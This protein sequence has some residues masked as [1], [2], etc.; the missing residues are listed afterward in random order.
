MSA[1][2]SAGALDHVSRVQRL[3]H[4]ESAPLAGGGQHLCL[5]ARLFLCF[6]SLLCFD[7][8]HFSNT[9]RF[10]T[11]IAVICAV[12]IHMYLFTKDQV[13][14]VMVEFQVFLSSFFN[15]S[16]LVYLPVL[17]GSRAARTP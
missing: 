11:K 6:Y 15:A 1:F 14:G 7:L 4:A 16:A 17:Q 8:Q 13:K 12:Y 5:P 9:F 3:V 2:P 10:I